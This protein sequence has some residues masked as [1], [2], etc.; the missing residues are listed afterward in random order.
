MQHVL[1]YLHR[2]LVWIIDEKKLYG[3]DIYHV[4]QKG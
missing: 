1:T 3:D 4:N 2:T